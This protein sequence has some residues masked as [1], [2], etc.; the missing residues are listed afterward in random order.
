MI[1]GL[2]M[3]A[4]LALVMQDETAL[5]AAP[6][7]TAPKQAVLY[8]GDAL[9]VR[10][11]RL[12]YW[13]VYDHRRERSGYVKVSSVRLS[14]FESE[15]APGLL[16]IVLFLKDSP[17]SEALGIAH[18]A[19]FLKA[20]PPTAISTDVFD[21]IGVM[22]DRLARRRPHRDADPVLLPAE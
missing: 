11:E 12:G 17:G 19:L 7:D 16:S 21:A 9:E 5:R 1:A 22:G 6:K 2:V 18:A 15:S 3:A 20:A 8:Q 13:Q 14:A 10:G 4:S